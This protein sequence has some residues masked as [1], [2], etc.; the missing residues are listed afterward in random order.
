MEQSER[1]G[2]IHGSQGVYL[3]IYFFLVGR[4]QLFE[5]EIFGPIVAV[6]TFDE[7]KEVVKRANNT[8]AGECRGRWRARMSLRITQSLALF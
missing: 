8:R 3:F 6:S 4:S 2:C 1:L 7:E 5:E